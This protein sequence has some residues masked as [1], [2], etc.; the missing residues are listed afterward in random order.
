MIFCA[1]VGALTRLPAAARLT[2]PALSIELREH[3]P[4]MEK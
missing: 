2:T 3:Q 4:A 1:E